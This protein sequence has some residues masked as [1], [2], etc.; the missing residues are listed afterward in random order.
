MRQ[1]SP[2]RSV[3]KN[4]LSNNTTAMSNYISN[5]THINNSSLNIQ[6]PQQISH[7]SSQQAFQPQNYQN[8]QNFQNTQSL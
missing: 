3:V 7:Q 8:Y 6:Q 1:H 5:Q 4:E 2:P